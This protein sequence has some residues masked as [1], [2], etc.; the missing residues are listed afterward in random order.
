MKKALLLSACTLALAAPQAFA[1]EGDM[2]SREEMWK[3]IQM[4][5]QQIEALQS[6]VQKQDKQIVQT[7]AEV[8]ETAK[9]VEAT[10]ETVANI[11][12]SA[13]GGNGWWEKTSL[14][15]YG[16]LH[17]N[18]GDEDEIDLHRFVVGL[19]HEFNEDIRFAGEIEIEHALS[20]DGAPG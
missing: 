3:M 9:V 10:Q 13:G 12:P 11:E 20:G 15:H 1:A 17:Y 5:Q 19:H 16:E 18:G 2:P 6:Q 4:Q 7:K 14:S 8:K